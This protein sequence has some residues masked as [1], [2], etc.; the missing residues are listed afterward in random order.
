VTDAVSG[1]PVTLGNRLDLRRGLTVGQGTGR[2]TVVPRCLTGDMQERPIMPG[3]SGLLERCE[4]AAG[5]SGSQSN[6]SPDRSSGMNAAFN[7]GAA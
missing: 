1:R 7:A 6:T 4:N 2:D 5:Q 3:T